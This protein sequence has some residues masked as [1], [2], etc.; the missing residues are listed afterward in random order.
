MI[1][2]IGR[3]CVKLAGRDAGKRCAIVGNEDD[4]LVLIDGETRRRKCN[5]LHLEP[6]GDVLELS[7]GA[8][9]DD[10]LAAFKEFGVEI[11]ESGS[12]EKKTAKKR[13]K[14]QKVVKKNKK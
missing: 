5:P 9:H 14:K 2:D 10:V 1:F 11:S 12:S 13:S 7:E 6:T 3:I 4:G 8:S